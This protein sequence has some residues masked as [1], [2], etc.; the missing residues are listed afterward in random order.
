MTHQ[1]TQA[2]TAVEAIDWLVGRLRWEKVL[3]ELHDRAEGV[4]PVAA[5]VVVTPADAES[6]ASGKDGERA[7]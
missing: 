6:A 7:A 1:T 4:E 5:P 3:R 2:D